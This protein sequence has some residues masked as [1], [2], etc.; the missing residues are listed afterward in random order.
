[1]RLYNTLVPYIEI[2][3]YGI[4]Y[5]VCREFKFVS[6][7]ASLRQVTHTYY[8]DSLTNYDYVS[9][10]YVKNKFTTYDRKN[11]IYSKNYKAE[12]AIDRPYAVYE[13]AQVFHEY[14][15]LETPNAFT[16]DIEIDYYE[17][18]TDE[19]NRLDLIA[20]K[21]FG[22]ATRSWIIAYMNKLEDGFSVRAGQKLVVPK[23]F[24]KLFDRDEILAP[25]AYDTLKLREE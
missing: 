13:N 2:P 21:L 18:P 4:V 22:S 5:G 14:L 15:A 24:D 7:Y 6:R 1:M 16:T 23:S 9:W 8:D 25:V 11:D 3:Y 19:E 20:Y 12:K 17:V 10:D